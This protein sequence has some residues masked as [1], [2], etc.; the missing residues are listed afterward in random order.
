MPLAVSNGLDAAEFW[1]GDISKTKLPCR[2]HMNSCRIIN[3]VNLLSHQ[4]LMTKYPDIV[5]HHEKFVDSNPF[6]P[7][8]LEGALNMDLAE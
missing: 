8:R 1:L 6:E 3:T 5:H 4:W 2:F 7:I